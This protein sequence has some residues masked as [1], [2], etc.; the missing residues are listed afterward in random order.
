MKKVLLATVLA[1]LSGCATGPRLGY[2]D[3][4]EDVYGRASR[5]EYA[6]KRRT[7]VASVER[8]LTDPLYT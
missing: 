8:L 5:M 1:A 7:V 6:Q 4:E 2:L 3:P